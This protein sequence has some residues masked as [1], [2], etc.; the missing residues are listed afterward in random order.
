MN[1]WRLVWAHVEVNEPIDFNHE[2]TLWGA[3]TYYY[4]ALR[5]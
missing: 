4:C 2:L 3:L 5:R 1:T